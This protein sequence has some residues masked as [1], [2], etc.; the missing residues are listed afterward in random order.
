MGKRV[1]SRVQRREEFLKRAGEMWE[2]LEDWYDAHPQAT[3]GELEQQARAQRRQLMGETLEI[4]LNQRSHAVEVQPAVCPQCGSLMKL[5]EIRGKTVHGLEGC[6]RVER[7]YYVC[8]AGCGQTA[9][10]PGSES[11]AARGLLE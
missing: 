5:H 9:F 6:T 7:S 8:S 2:A 10:P 1:S 11:A 4:L 3:F